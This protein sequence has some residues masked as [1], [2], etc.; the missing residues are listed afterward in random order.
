MNEAVQELEQHDSK[1]ADLQKEPAA[2][3]RTKKKS[4]QPFI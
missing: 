4:K 1:E 2:M 3:Q